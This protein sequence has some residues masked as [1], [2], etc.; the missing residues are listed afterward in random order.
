MATAAQRQLEA[1]IEAVR[2]EM[3]Q[4]KN[5]LGLAKGIARNGNVEDCKTWVFNIQ[6][7]AWQVHLASVVKPLGST[8]EEE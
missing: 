6:A 4:L 3:E 2:D 7:A 1:R 5:T 8:Q